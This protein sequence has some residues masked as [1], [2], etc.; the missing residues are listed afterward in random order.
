MPFV[1]DTFDDVPGTLLQDHVAQV[2][3]QWSRI[4]GGVG[5][6]VVNSAGRLN[7]DVTQ[8]YNACA[9]EL[10]GAVPDSPNYDLFVLVSRINNNDDFIGVDFCKTAGAVGTQSFYRVN[11]DRTQNPDQWKLWRYVDGV[12][13]QMG[14]TVLDDIVSTTPAPAELQ[15]FFMG[16][17][18]RKRIYAGNHLLFDWTETTIPGIG[19][20]GL[21]YS[22]PSYGTVGVSTDV[23]FTSITGR[24]VDGIVPPSF[25]SYTARAPLLSQR[26]QREQLTRPWPSE[27]VGR[28]AFF[29]PIAAPEVPL[30]LPLSMRIAEPSRT[31]LTL[32]SAVPTALRIQT[33]SA[34]LRLGDAVPTQLRIGES[35]PTSLRVGQGVP[36][37]LDIGEEALAAVRLADPTPTTMR[38]EGH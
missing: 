18:D 28:G 2:G 26:W 38:L 24:T 4:A 36:A 30:E 20:M 10:P 25:V 3:G 14:A 15:L 34:A 22:T 9:Y 6:L 27:L 11:V 33:I 37:V 35:T 23:Q 21:W 8:N 17:G 1:L 7:V 13:T 19:S 29:G 16:R 32:S 31:S 12:P 5:N